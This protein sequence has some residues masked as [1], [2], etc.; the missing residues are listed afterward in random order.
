[1]LRVAAFSKRLKLRGSNG[2]AKSYGD[3]YGAVVG[4]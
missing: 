1:M 4:S 2:R 3:G